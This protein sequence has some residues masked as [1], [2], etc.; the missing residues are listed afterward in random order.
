IRAAVAEICTPN[1]GALEAQKRP[2]LFFL[3]SL[4]VGAVKLNQGVAKVIR[5]ACGTNRRDR[6]ADR[7]NNNNN[8]NVVH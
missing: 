3:N 6:S 8:N 4:V 7:Y 5:E 2:K 1:P